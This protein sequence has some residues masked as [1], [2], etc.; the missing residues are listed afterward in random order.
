MSESSTAPVIDAEGHPRVSLPHALISVGLLLIFL[1]AFTAHQIQTVG[2]S[3]RVES[4]RFPSADGKR[5]SALLYTPDGVDVEHKAPGIL[6]VHGYINSRETQSGFAIEFARRGY[7]VL[8]LDQS[9]HGLSRPPAFANGFGGPDAL[10]YLRALD[11]VDIDNI[12]LEGHSMGGWAVLARPPSTTRWIQS[13]GARR[14][15]TGQLR[16][17][18]GTQT[19]PRNLAVVF[20]AFDEFSELMWGVPTGADVVRSPK[21][22]EIFGTLEPVVPGK[23]YGYLE[24]DSARMLHV[25][26]VT[27]P[28]DHLS[29]AAIGAAVDWFAHD[30]EGRHAATG[31]PP[32]LVLEGSHHAGALVGMIITVI[33]LGLTMLQWRVGE[34]SD[35]CR[36]RPLRGSCGR[37]SARRLTA[38]VPVLT[39]FPLFNVAPVFWPVSNL[40]PQAADERPD[41][42][43]GRE[44]ADRRR[45]NRHSRP[46]FRHA[47]VGGFVAAGISRRAIAGCG[48]RRRRHRWHRVRPAARDRRRLP[49][50]LPFLGDRVQTPRTV[51]RRAVLH[52][53]DA[54][55]AVLR[56][57][58]HVA[59]INS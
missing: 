38:L 22:K 19:F 15:C 49:G 43:G 48:S 6:A 23:L 20:T 47:R 44:H 18:A 51:A 11:T 40:A 34:V 13:H 10:R 55:D 39:Y 37:A 25:P 7:V 58:R 3:V 24:Y 16:C 57:A 5:L 14:L 29:T 32:D 54:D 46:R 21:L 36:F 41:A 30:V 2:G 53:S 9:G 52:V 56:R 27:H 50:R 33:G 12:G 31:A 26:P 35:A 1:G 59:C 4:V 45:G 8:A 17:A 42:V 28:G